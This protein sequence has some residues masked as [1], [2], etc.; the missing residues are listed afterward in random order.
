MGQAVAR[1]SVIE[2][3]WVKD[4]QH[5]AA[6]LRDF[7][8]VVETNSHQMHYSVAS[9][10]QE[11]AKLRSG[12]LPRWPRTEVTR[13]KSV[14]VVWAKSSSPTRLPKLDSNRYSPDLPADRLP[15]H[16]DQTGCL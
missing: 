9:S 14:K 1:N 16:L 6:E 12:L 3:K 13:R 11:L 5:F 2:R 7:R 8:G 10:D 4:S 15:A